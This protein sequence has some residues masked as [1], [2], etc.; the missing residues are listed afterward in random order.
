MQKISKCVPLRST[1]GWI[2]GHAI[3]GALQE[4]HR[5]TDSGDGHVDDVL[6]D[7]RHPVE[8]EDKVHRNADRSVRGKRAVGD[9]DGCG[10]EGG[11]QVL[12]EHSG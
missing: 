6:N 8:R 10:P 9:H 12:Q 5:R 11:P 3:L 7:L 1:K 2:S 4:V